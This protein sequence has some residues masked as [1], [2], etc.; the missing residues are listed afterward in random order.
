MMR[1][2]TMNNNKGRGGERMTRRGANN[3]E[4]QEGKWRHNEG[5][6]TMQEGVRQ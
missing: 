2:G 5:E 4:A 3:N 6:G 1:G